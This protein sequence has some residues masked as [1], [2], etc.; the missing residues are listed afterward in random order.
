MISYALDAIQKSGLFDV[1]H[2]STDSSRICET[3]GSL[4]FPV[5]F[6][7]PAEL[8]DD[9]TPIMPVLK[10]VCNEYKA[11][12]VEFDQVWM[13]TPTSPFL[14]PR[15]LLAA[16]ALINQGQRKAPLLAVSEYQAPIEWA[17][18]LSVDGALHP[19]QAGMFSVR[20][21]DIEPKYFDVGS[22]AAFPVQHV[23]DS[24]EAGSDSDFIGIVLPKY[25]AIDI[26]TPDDWELAEALYLGLQIQKHKSND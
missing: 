21:Q 7:R 19:L 24:E 10:Y 1:V 6:L 17:F 13:I 9:Y 18:R 26:D 20:S 14:E 23:L 25:K 2:V 12:G 8:A 15:D 5:D 11:R 22:F 16:S 3:V 4:G